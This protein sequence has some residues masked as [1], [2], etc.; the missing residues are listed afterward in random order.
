MGF[1]WVSLGGALGAAS[2][3]AIYKVCVLLLTS[4]QR[5][6]L[7][8]HDDYSSYTIQYRH[9]PQILWRFL[10]ELKRIFVQH[11]SSFNPTK[12]LGL[13]MLATLFANLI[14]AFL[15]GMIYWRLPSGPLK[16]WLLTGFLGGL[17]TLSSFNVELIDL[18]FAREWHKAM[19][20]LGI[21]LAGSLGMA[22]LGFGLANLVY[23]SLK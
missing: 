19:F 1:L 21:T 2:R 20:Y 8:T 17:T 12:Y 14:G 16:L 18:A 4:S 13:P 11:Q 10:F 3:Y 22:L 7:L 5:K 9:E 15:A 6:G 23:Q